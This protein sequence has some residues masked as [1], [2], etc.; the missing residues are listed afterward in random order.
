MHLGMENFNCT[1]LQALFYKPHF[2][3]EGKFYKENFKY[4][5]GKFYNDNFKPE[6]FRVDNFTQKIFKTD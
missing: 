2:F 4:Q 1:F 3:R 5:A 6:Y